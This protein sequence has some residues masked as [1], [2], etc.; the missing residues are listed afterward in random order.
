MRIIRNRACAR[1]GLIGNPSDGY[2]GKTISF[3]IRDYWAE[4]VL[5]EWEDVEV[6]SSRDD[7]SRFRGVRDLVQ[8]VKQHGYYGGIRLVKATIKKFVEYCDDREIALHDRNF[9][10]R[11]QTNIPRQ[12]GLAGSSAIIVATL[13]SLMDFYEVEI[14]LEVQPSLALSV[15]RDELGIAA[16]LQ[17]RVVQVY[18]NLIYM[19]FADDRVTVREGLECGVYE[20]LATPAPLPIYVAFNETVSEPGERVHN[21]LRERYEARE[22]QVVGAMEKLAALADEARSVILA[23]DVGRLG[24]L[25]DENFDIRCTIYNMAEEQKQMVLCA[26][27]AGATA[28]FA[29]S[30]GAIVGTYQDADGF[31]RL[32]T[33]L[34][35]I[36]CVVLRPRIGRP[37]PA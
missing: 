35:A 20:P 32:T 25:I 19:D 30:G 28:K 22:P 8:D 11:Y 6:L 12:V 34:E 23:G 31:A 10:V 13:R 36:G 15:E 3:V 33:A 1:A 5:Y 24:E 26:R 18:E 29:G 9:S 16:G 14:P 4:A 27:C 7:Q 2:S 37:T 17:D 21:N